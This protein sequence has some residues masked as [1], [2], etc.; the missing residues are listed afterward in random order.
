MLKSEDFRPDVGEENVARRGE[1]GPSSKKSQSHTQEQRQQAEQLRVLA[2]KVKKRAQKR[3]GAAR[4]ARGSFHGF[5]ANGPALSASAGWARVEGKT[6]KRPVASKPFVAPSSI[7]TLRKSARELPAEGPNLPGLPPT[8][9]AKTVPP[10][11]PVRHEVTTSQIAEIQPAL[12]QAQKHTRAN[13]KRLW[14][15]V[16]PVLLVGVG[17]VA[18]QSRQTSE[19]E[20]LAL[21]VPTVRP[22]AI[23]PVEVKPTP[24]EK[25]QKKTAVIKETAT[26]VNART[27]ELEALLQ[28][29]RKG[30]LC[31]WC[32]QI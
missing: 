17:L 27:T 5:T 9:R 20:A 7:P 29:F 31:F 18:W 16:V 19:N 25:T 8:R 24:A 1:L 10:P 11:V 15:A 26:P 13:A 4:R 6:E 3:S 14:L 23:A 22:A 30:F 21:E 32:G 2:A 12:E 28:R